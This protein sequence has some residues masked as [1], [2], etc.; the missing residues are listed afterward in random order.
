[1]S[2]VHE[3]SRRTFLKNAALLTSAAAFPAFISKNSG[4][5]VN[6]AC[7]GIGNQGGLDVIPVFV[8]LSRFAMWTWGLPKP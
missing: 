8:I 7:I 2:Q 4:D 1:M 5:K 6:L 3:S